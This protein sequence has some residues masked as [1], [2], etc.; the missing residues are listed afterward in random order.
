MTKN[1]II[2]FKYFPDFNEPTIL[3]SGG[4]DSYH[5]FADIFTNTANTGASVRLETDTLFVAGN[6]SVILVRA[7][8]AKGMRKISSSRFEWTLTS[9]ICRLF[10]KKIFDF[11]ELPV[12]SASHD[13]LDCGSLDEVQVVIS[14]GEYDEKIFM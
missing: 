2:H 13:Y 8:I 5:M 12:S 10:A 1:N 7:D 9:E 4:S 3:F 6:V 11:S 14:R